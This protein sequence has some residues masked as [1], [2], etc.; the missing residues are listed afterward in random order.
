[1]DLYAEWCGPC[2]QLTPRLE[3]RVKKMEGVKMVKIDIDKCP[4]IASALQVKSV[5]TV[6]LVFQGQAVDGFNGNVPDA[7]MDR[8]FKT[9]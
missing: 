7:E 1:M 3:E 9:I 8:F 6:Y 4:Q 2:K 5:P